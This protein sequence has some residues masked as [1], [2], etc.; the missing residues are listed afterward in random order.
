MKAHSIGTYHWE[1]T[2]PDNWSL[3]KIV[4]DNVKKAV[5]TF[6]DGMRLVVDFKPGELAIVVPDDISLE[7]GPLRDAFS[8]RLQDWREYPQEAEGAL[9]WADY[10]SELAT[11]IRA[12]VQ[13]AQKPNQ[14]TS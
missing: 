12:A 7:C 9:A 6:A 13:Q 8:W 3:D 11:E 5:A 10:L 1:A 4:S 14:A 2:T